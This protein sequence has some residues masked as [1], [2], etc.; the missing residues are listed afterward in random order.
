AR[1]V[2][3]EFERAKLHALHHRLPG[4][5]IRNVSGYSGLYTV[6]RSDVHPIVGETPIAGLFAANGC[7]GH[8][9][10]LAPALGALLARQIVGSAG[11]FDTRVSPDFLA[12]GRK[13]I[14]LESK[15]VLA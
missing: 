11:S 15:S 4:L 8:A 14:A 9:F 12:V 6:N 3:V 1:Y 7:S 2:D 13:P 10:K 5:S